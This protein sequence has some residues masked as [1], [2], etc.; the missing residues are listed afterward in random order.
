MP[1]LSG[2]GGYSHHIKKASDKKFI[3]KQ[4]NK[5]VVQALKVA[6]DFGNLEDFNNL[7][8]YAKGMSCSI[9]L[10][11]MRTKKLK[12]IVFENSCD[13]NQKDSS[14]NNDVKTIKK[15]RLPKIKI[16]NSVI[17]SGSISEAEEIGRQSHC[18]PHQL[19]RFLII[20]NES[21]HQRQHS[22]D[23]IDALLTKFFS[24]DSKK[25]AERRNQLEEDYR[26]NLQESGNTS[27]DRLHSGCIRHVS[28]NCKN[29]VD[30]KKE[31]RSEFIKAL[32]WIV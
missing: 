12:N 3:K 2:F 17:F 14:L 31:H 26:I 20:E 4:W 21:A 9:V 1:E 5:D 28:F 15:I 10:E 30:F 8:V 13:T 24:L 29:S 25:G 32:R 16:E 7:V 6:A 23:I 27:A 11:V 18:L 22:N 19:P